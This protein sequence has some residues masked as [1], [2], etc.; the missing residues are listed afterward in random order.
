MPTNAAAASAT[1]TLFFSE[2]LPIR[3]TASSTMASTAAFRPKN[4]ATMIGTL[5]HPA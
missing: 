1:M 2:R 3:K 5:P 4:R